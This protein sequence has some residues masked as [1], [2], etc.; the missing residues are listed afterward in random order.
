MCRLEGLVEAG[1]AG[2][3]GLAGNASWEQA[4]GAGQFSRLLLD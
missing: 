4:Q 2:A 1:M 3:A